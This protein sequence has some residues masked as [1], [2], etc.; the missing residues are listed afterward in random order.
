[1]ASRLPAGVG[2]ALREAGGGAVLV[3]PWMLS[4]S[5]ALPPGHAW[6]N[7]GLLA[8]YRHLGRLHAAALG[9]LGVKTRAVPPEGVV[10]AN[11][12]LD[13]GVAWACF[14]SLSPYE[15]TSPQG[16]KLVGLAQRRQRNGVLLVAGS[17][18]R[19][20]DWALLCQVMGRP[21]D[22]PKLLRCATCCEDLAAGVFS[23]EALALRLREALGE[24]LGAG[25]CGARCAATD[26]TSSG[27]ERLFR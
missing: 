14:G 15:L 10:R 18:C 8:A 23:I 4:V 27:G 11:Q 19:Q 13:G 9:S 25:E 16:R 26:A 5:V 21:D 17:L 24:A 7:G 12:G 3:G 6:V 20:P 22:L 1:V 2:L